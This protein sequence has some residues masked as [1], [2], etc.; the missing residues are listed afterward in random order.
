MTDGARITRD[1]GGKPRLQK[2]LASAGYG[3][4]RQC[5]QLIVDG[6]VEVDRKVANEL[7]VRVDPATQ[8]VRVD[9]VVLKL[10]RHKYFMLQRTWWKSL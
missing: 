10:P 6:R 4:R 3:S 5:E 8:H 7:G 1:G 2:I 9:G